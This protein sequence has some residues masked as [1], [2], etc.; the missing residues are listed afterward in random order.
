M[1][2]F[3]I[4]D[5]IGNRYKVLKVLGGQGITGRGIIF[6][7]ID[8]EKPLHKKV[9]ALKSLQERYLEADF[10]IDAFKREALAW[11]QLDNHPFIVKA[12]YLEIIENRPFLALE[13]IAPDKKARNNLS[14]YLE[15]PISLTQA[16][17]WGIQFCIGMEHAQSK[18]IT[19]HRDIKPDN[20]MITTRKTLKISDFGLALFSGKDMHISK[21]KDLAARGDSEYSFLRFSRGDFFGGT[22]PWMAPEQF[23]TETDLRGDIYSFGI[24]LY[25][26]FNKGQL[27]FKCL[28][29]DEYEK[30]HKVGMIKKL[31]TKAFPIIE[32]CLKKDPNDR[33]QN[34]KDFRKDLEILY[35]KSGKKKVPRAPKEKDLNSF[36]HFDKGMSF[37]ALGFYED[38]K[39]EFENAIREKPNFEKAFFQLGLIYK[40]IKLIEK[41]IET[42]KKVLEINPKSK[43]ALEELKTLKK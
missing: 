43:L 6:V 40:S 33:Y 36:E 14:H 21:W 9:I 8:Y 16:L 13:Y 39:I 12:K 30:A 7:C 42:F 31:E 4:G 2:S 15:R 22:I 11:V 38:A 32:K 29:E 1:S 41:S 27:P 23:D 19:P 10:I 5:L 25:Q 18:G 35:L 24:I 37:K 20:I 26:M 28:N 34:F 3:K 17:K